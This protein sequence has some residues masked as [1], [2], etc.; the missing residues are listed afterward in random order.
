MF[1][2]FISHVFAYSQN[3]R[4]VAFGD[5]LTAGFRLEKS[6][7]FP[8]ILQQLLNTRGIKSE[9]VNAGV[10]GDTSAQALKR[11]DWVLKKQ[12]FDWAI[13]CI[14]ANDGLRNQPLAQLE[15]NVTEIVNKFQENEIKVLLFGMKLPVNLDAKYRQ[16]FEAVFARVARN[17][18]TYYSPFLLDGVAGQP[19]LQLE[20]QIHPNEEGQKKVA[21]NVANVLVDILSLK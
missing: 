15:K 18:K 8:S 5:S 12:K 1:F 9:V 17:K 21:Q 2:L 20:D 3:L 7:A 14:G 13:I 4:I 19:E 10:S 6:K 11:V 16:D